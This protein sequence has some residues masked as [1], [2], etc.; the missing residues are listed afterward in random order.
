MT[1]A[2]TAPLDLSLLLGFRYACRPE[3]G[4]CCYAQPRVD[5]EEQPT[6]LRIAPD[7]RFVGH[8]SDRFLASY[9][10]GGACRLLRSNRCAV[11]PARP[12]PC[13]EFPLTVHVGG[14]LQATVVLTCPGVELDPLRVPRARRE[15]PPQG[16]ESELA[17]IRARTGNRGD[18]R[19]E[20][21]LRRGRRVERA[22]RAE[23]R[24]VED[25]VVRDVVR[26]DPPRPSD[27]EFPVENPPE[28]S[29]GMANLP[30]FF[31]GRRAPVAL[32][33]RWGSWELLEL[34]PTGGGASLGVIPPPERCPELRPPA[35]ALLDGYL[36]YVL[37]RDAF[38]ASVQL[39]ALEAEDGT[40]ADWARADLV[41]LGAVV[42][43]RGSVRAKL[44]GRGNGPLTVED[45]ANG[46]R[47]T[48]M[49]WL[50]R[51]TWGDRL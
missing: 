18:A 29:D 30:L 24:W 3:C 38:L 13:R 22:L 35:V 46:I 5:P 33:N 36:D 15:E 44:A 7:A 51:P 14:R 49:D 21:A 34:S 23:G 25:A 19:W 1:D 20:A 17:S 11:H 41:E 6:V 45:V 9:P 31:D 27:R 32:A 42:L 37:E 28:V 40:V 10:D 12:H 2:P 4:L 43:A 50:D 8:G 26:R 48:D 39:A 47:A 16:F